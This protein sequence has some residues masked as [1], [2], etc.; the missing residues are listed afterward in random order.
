MHSH[1]QSVLGSF[2]NRCLNRACRTTGESSAYGTSARSRAAWAMPSVRSSASRCS[3]SGVVSPERKRLGRMTPARRASH[4]HGS[5]AHLCRRSQPTVVSAKRCDVD[6]DCKGRD[7]C[8]KRKCVECA[9]NKDCKNK[10][11]CDNNKCVECKK[12]SDCNG[13]EVARTK[14]AGS[15]SGAGLTP[16]RFPGGHP[17][18]DALRV[19]RRKG[20]RSDP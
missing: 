3:P 14:S 5:R 12:N 1:R 17:H 4:R 16:G 18:A 6:S 11:R 15:R 10:E 9:R 13:T 20:V 8:D 2:G 7:V 19:L